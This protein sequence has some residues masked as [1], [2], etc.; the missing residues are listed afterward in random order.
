MTSNRHDWRFQIFLHWL[1]VLM[2]T[3]Q[4]VLRDRIVDLWD[5]RMSGAMPNVA[6][7]DLHVV[8]G[9]MILMVAL[10]RLILVARDGLPPLPGNTSP[11]LARLVRV[12]DALFYIV[13]IAMPVSGIIAWTFGSVQAIVVHQIC[14]ALLAALI[15]IHIAGPLYM[16]VRGR[17]SLPKRMLGLS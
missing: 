3:L 15:V 13:L 14:E 16:L 7:S 11:A 12:M 4:Y 2:I 10:W 5:A 6:M 17:I 8:L 9:V 1:V